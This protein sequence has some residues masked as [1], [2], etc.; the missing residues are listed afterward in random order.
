MSLANRFFAGMVLLCVLPLR[1]C[2]LTVCFLKHFPTVLNVVLT[3][4]TSAFSCAPK[5]DESARPR[6]SAGTTCL[7]KEEI[8]F[9]QKALPVY[10]ILFIALYHY[11]KRR[12]P[13]LLLIQQSRGIV[14]LFELNVGT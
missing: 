10:R 14:S 12:E 5:S 11:L 13:I 8:V 6:F 7:C 2:F 4:T 9:P 1:K 3:V